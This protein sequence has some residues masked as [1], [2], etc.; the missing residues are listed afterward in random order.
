MIIIIM[1]TLSWDSFDSLHSTLCHLADRLYLF[2]FKMVVVRFK[3]GIVQFKMGIVQ[4]K[5]EKLL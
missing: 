5:I 4:F 1:I 2:Q 3:M